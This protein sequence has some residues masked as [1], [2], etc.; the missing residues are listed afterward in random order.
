M[1]A[2]KNNETPKRKRAT[3]EEMIERRRQELAELEAKANGTY[4]PTGPEAIRKSILKSR[5]I[6]QSALN[7][8][9]RELAG[10]EATEK[11]PAIAPLVDRIENA[12]QRLADLREKLDTYTE[13]T[14]NLPEDIARLDKL[15]EDHDAGKTNVEFPTDLSELEQD[16][17]AN[18]MTTETADLDD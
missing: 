3:R 11:S 12:E 13:Q 7:L 14:L 9:Q 18:A 5:R 10:R 4:V 15:I 17:V 8:A 1:T 6:R 16:T 2:D